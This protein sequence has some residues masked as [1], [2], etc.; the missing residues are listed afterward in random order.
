MV[1]VPVVGGPGADG[2][3]VAEADVEG[4]AV[5]WVWLG[6]LGGPLQ[7]ETA[8]ATAATANSASG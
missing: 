5:G 8:A 4:A 2:G 6:V 1:E 7:A 3:E